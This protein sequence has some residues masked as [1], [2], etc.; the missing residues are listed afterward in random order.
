MEKTDR[1]N[2]G[3]IK[4]FLLSVLLVFLFGISTIHAGVNLV[5]PPNDSW[6]ND[7]LLTL[8]IITLEL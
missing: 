7:T 3:A 5:A 6:T 2:F 8:L 4:G 1:L